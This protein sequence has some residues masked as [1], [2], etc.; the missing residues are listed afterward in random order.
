MQDLNTTYVF[1][2]IFYFLVELSNTAYHVN[3]AA[4]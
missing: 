3:I 1:L 4:V 2:F